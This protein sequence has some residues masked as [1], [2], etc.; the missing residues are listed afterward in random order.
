M[1]NLAVSVCCQV[2]AVRRGCPGV[3]K[4]P[5]AGWDKNVPNLSWSRWEGVDTNGSENETRLVA[6]AQP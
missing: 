6:G 1:S 4:N 2:D 5:T 3:C